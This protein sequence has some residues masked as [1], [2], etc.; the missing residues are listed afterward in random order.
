MSSTQQDLL[1]FSK[2]NFERP[3]VGV[4]FLFN[5]PEGIKRL[6][7]EVAFCEM[8]KEAQQ[9]VTPFYADIENLSC[10]P[11]AYAWG[12]DISEIFESGL[13]GV[14][15]KIFK[16]AR[17]N[18]RIY[19][20]T[21]RL[22]PGTVNY[23]AFSPLDKLSFDP[24]LLIILTDNTSQTELILRAMMYTTGE[25]WTS[26]MTNVLGCAWVFAY[27]FVT[28]K[29]N[30]VTTGL[31]CGMKAKKVF[32]EGRQII[33]IPFNWLPTITQNLQDME[34]VLPAY[35]A[36]NIGEFVARLYTELGVPPS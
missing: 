8:T 19:E 4:K 20:Y 1:V 36:D 24:D 3:P 35:T 17:A 29:V 28:G 11:S 12:H 5:K 34:W 22:A 26:E 9:S 25:M 14:A 13:F 16:E 30:Y 21:P 2:F 33:S 10:A 32:P 6:D 27:P 23:I 7:K 18:R 15:L 31:S